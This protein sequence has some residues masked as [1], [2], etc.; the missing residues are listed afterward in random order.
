MLKTIEVGD[1]IKFKAV[2]TWNSNLVTRI[3]IGFR[4]GDK[5]QPEVRFGGFNFV[6]KPEEIKKVIKKKR[7]QLT[8]EEE[9]RCR[10][11]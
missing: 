1:Q 3:V 4:D 11:L 9:I 7:L 8:E 2:T 6:V 10:K 5:T